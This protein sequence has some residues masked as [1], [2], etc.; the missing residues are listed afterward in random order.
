MLSLGS[1]GW[2][3]SISI[4]NRSSF[5]SKLPGLWLSSF[6]SIPDNSWTVKLLQTIAKTILKRLFRVYAHIYHQH[7][8][9]DKTFY[10]M[11]LSLC[12]TA[13]WNWLWVC[14]PLPFQEIVSLGE[15]AHLNTSFKHFVYFIQASNVTFL[16]PS[17]LLIC[18]ISF[19]EFELIDKKELAPLQVKTL[20]VVLA[21][22]IWFSRDAIV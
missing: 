17:S 21:L 1:A 19:Q 8:K 15:E 10:N 7:F 3:D 18:E 14:A 13:L 6:T 12:T 11:V 20:F 2:W 9:V 5:S 4:Q 16:I 22:A